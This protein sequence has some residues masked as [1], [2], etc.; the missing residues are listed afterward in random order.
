MKRLVCLMLAVLLLVCGCAKADEEKKIAEEKGNLFVYEI[1]KEVDP[2][3]ANKLH[4][5]DVKR[6]IRAL[7]IF[8]SGIKKSDIVDDF[9][10]KYDYNAYSIDFPREVLYQRIKKRVDIM[11]KNGLLTEIEDLL[12]KGVTKENQCMQAIGY[13]EIIDYIEG[14][15]SLEQAIENI[16]LNTRHYAKRQIT[17]FKRLSKLELLQPTEINLLAQ[18]ITKDLLK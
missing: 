11:V 8:E 7:E 10:P 3:S 13:K 5:N 2:E 14:N 15:C 12:S 18:S 9:T 1:L 4:F 16:K 6:V 17:F